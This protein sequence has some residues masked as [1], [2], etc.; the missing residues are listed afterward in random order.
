VLLLVTQKPH[1]AANE[2][3]G[4][5]IGAASVRWVMAWLTGDARRAQPET[6][7]ETAIQARGQRAREGI[8]PSLQSGAHVFA[9]FCLSVQGPLRHRRIRRAVTRIATAGTI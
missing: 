2:V 4:A 6:L 5:V 3:G 9:C 1:S 8:L 7:P